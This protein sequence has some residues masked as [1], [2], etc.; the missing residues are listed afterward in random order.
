MNK[1]NEMLDHFIDNYFFIVLFI[2]LLNLF[3]TLILLQLLN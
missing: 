2:F 3:G 1:F